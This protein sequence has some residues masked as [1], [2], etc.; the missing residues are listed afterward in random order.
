MY[1]NVRWSLFSVTV[2]MVKERKGKL[3]RPEV[4]NKWKRRL[5]SNFW[6]N[7]RVI[8]PAS[9]ARDEKRDPQTV[10]F[11]MARA[12]HRG[13]VVKALLDLSDR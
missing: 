7:V 2:K 8:T 6:S 9:L 5:K 4:I 10:F 3:G 13:S 12:I 1:K 11:P